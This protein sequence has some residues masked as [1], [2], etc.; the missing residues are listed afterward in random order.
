MIVG[1]Q[2]MYSKEAKSSAG[3]EMILGWQNEREDTACW[4]QGTSKGRAVD[5]G[6]FQGLPGGAGST[7]GLQR[8]GGAEE[9][10]GKP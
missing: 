7:H 10:T 3:W 1:H 2:K 9:R 4:T 6:S 8:E 5:T